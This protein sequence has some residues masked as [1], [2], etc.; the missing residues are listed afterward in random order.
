VLSEE[1]IS[2]ISKHK[3]AHDIGYCR[4]PCF[5]ALMKVG[6]AMMS[7]NKLMANLAKASPEAAA[8]ILEMKGEVDGRTDPE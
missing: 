6:E 2:S 4:C 3:M 7:E 1:E 5:D 8:A